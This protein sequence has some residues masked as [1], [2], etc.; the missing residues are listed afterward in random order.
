MT[1][2]DGHPH[3]LTGPR[4]ATVIV[5]WLAVVSVAASR[6]GLYYEALAAVY[7]LPSVGL[8]YAYCLTHRGRAAALLAVAATVAAVLLIG[9]AMVIP[10]GSGA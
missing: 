4:I 1:S 6:L 10:K 8:I 7:V 3:V 5:A 9:S 2:A